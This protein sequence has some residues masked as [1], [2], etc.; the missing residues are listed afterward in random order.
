MR[1]C[2]DP[3][4]KKLREIFEANILKIPEARFQPLVT[5]ARIDKKNKYWGELPTMV[6]GDIMEMYDLIASSPMADIAGKVSKST[7]VD[8]GLSILEGFLK[9]F[10]L[11]SASIAAHF[12]G[13]SKVAFSFKNVVRQ[14]FAP[15][16]LVSFINGIPLDTTRTDSQQIIN[17]EMALYVID[18]IIT[19]SDFSIHATNSSGGNLGLDIPVIQGIVSQ[20]NAGVAVQKESETSISFQ[21]DKPLTFAFT[22]LKCDVDPAGR[23]TLKPKRL[24]KS[25]FIE[26][27]NTLEHILFTEEVEMID[28]VD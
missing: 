21:G 12:S 11:P 6:D 4:V 3:V 5:I 20:A 27:N 7:N 24:P 9:G 17:G 1:L 14:Y 26:N 28:F 23:I 19:S 18:S 8:I 22:C 2:P 13:A 25:V 16:D 10:S 15:A